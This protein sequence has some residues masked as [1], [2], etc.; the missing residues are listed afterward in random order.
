MTDAERAASPS[1]RAIRGVFHNDNDLKESGRRC[2]TASFTWDTTQTIGHSGRR[3]GRHHQSHL[4]HRRA[5]SQISHVD[6][7]TTNRTL[8]DQRADQNHELWL[9]SSIAAI[10][11]LR[12]GLLRRNC[13]MLLSLFSIMIA[14]GRH[15]QL[16]QFFGCARNKDDRR[17]CCIR[18]A[19]HGGTSA[20]TI[21][22]Q[23]IAVPAVIRRKS[24]PVSERVA[25]QWSQAANGVTED[26][27]RCGWFFWTDRGTRLAPGP[28]RSS[29]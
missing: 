8:F 19:S 24:M 6:T 22:Y 1:G 29:F 13:R 28:Q 3:P 21:A 14:S 27:A 5:L 12:S 17:L 2:P 25:L 4:Q 18:H 23:N 9:Y 7:T 15:R 16:D 26:A 20:Q 11:L 10:D